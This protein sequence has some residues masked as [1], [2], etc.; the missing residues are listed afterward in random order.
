MQN[1][2][3]NFTY[4]GRFVVQVHKKQKN[5]KYHYTKQELTSKMIPLYTAFHQLTRGP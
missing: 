2:Y 4:Y 3:F 5:I 1:I